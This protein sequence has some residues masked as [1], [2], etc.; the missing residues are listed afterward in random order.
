M[1]FTSIEELKNKKYIDVELPG[2]D[3][4]DVF[5]CRLQRVNLLDLAAKGQIPNP[6]MGAV[7]QLFK[8]NGPSP[9]D[10][11]ALKIIKD[12]SELFC[13]VTMVEPK[14]KDVQ[15]AIGLT[16]EQKVIIYNYAVKGAKVLEPFRK[17]SEDAKSSKHG[18][19]VSK[20][21]KSNNEN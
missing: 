19:A 13:E 15:E 17:K 12:L 6:L 18:E 5:K 16:D 2:W 1:E 3:A 21:T 11:N 20:D 4:N 10:E 9:D 8:G 14:F 7:I